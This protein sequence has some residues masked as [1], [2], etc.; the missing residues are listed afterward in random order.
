[1]TSKPG[2]VVELA[3]GTYR[4]VA[5]G[6]GLETIERELELE[7]GG[8]AEFSVELCAQPEQQIASIAGQVLEQRTCASTVE[9]ESAFMIL[10]EYAEQLVKDRG[11]RTQQCAKWRA[12]AEPEG[13]WTLDTKCDGE[14]SATTCRIEISAGACAVTGPRRT[15]RGETCPRAELR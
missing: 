3:P 8:A 10:S 13:K 1:V 5:S 4:V 7:G 14:V 2:D 9:C 11:F 12:G 6:P 15:V